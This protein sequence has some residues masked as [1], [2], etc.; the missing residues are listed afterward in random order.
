[1]ENNIT[2]QNRAHYL[3]EAPVVRSP[4]DIIAEGV[5]RSTKITDEKTVTALTEKALK[6]EPYGQQGNYDVFF[7]GIAESLENIRCETNSQNEYFTMIE[8]AQRIMDHMTDGFVS[9]EDLREKHH[10]IDDSY[11]REAEILTCLSLYERSDHPRAKERHA[12]LLLK[13][14]RL[15][16]LRSALIVNTKDKAD[17]KPLTPDELRRLHLTI[18]AL[19]DIREADEQGD[20]DNEI[21]RRHLELLQISHMNDFEFYPNYSFYTR[22]LE[23]QRRA[24]IQPREDEYQAERERHKAR[25]A[26]YA[27]RLAAMRHRFDTREDVRDRIMRLT[28]RKVSTATENDERQ[29]YAFD[30]ETFR[31]LKEMHDMQRLRSE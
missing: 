27:L 20:Y 31:R 18:R 10:F 4:R 21:N 28:G 16:Q 6:G 17:Q 19:N 29:E 11:Q 3:Q 24:D 13:L 23:D 26:N 2:E 30:A 14:R 9:E 25:E 5:R 22:M 12:E 1:M 8:D 15:R 7:F